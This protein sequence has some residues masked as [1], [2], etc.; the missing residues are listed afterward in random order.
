MSDLQR[1]ADQEIFASSNEYRIPQRVSQRIFFELKS[2][3]FFL[4]GWLV[5]FINQF[6][7]LGGFDNILSRILSTE[8]K[9]TI[10][11]IVALLKPWGLCYEYL[12]QSTI[13]KYFTPI[14]VRIST[15]KLKF[16]I[17]RFFLLCRI[18]SQ[19]FSI[20]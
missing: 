14:I 17:S 10:S 7:D 5:D 16:F 12:T 20:N 18:S 3:C 19:D 9:L 8:S 4:K 11:V 6:G 15:E 1:T 13:K 2:I